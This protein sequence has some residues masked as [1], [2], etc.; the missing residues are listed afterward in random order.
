VTGNFFTGSTTSP[1]PGEDSRGGG[2]KIR[3]TYFYSY[4]STDLLTPSSPRVFQP[5][6]TANRSWLPYCSTWSEC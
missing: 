4:H 2:A 3:T 5:V 1:N 6:L